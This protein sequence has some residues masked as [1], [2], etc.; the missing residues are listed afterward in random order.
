MG[1]AITR[2]TIRVALLCYFGAAAVRLR[3]RPGAASA[4]PAGQPLGRRASLGIRLARALWT[5]GC[6]AFLLHVASAFY[7]YH[8]GSHAAAFRHTAQRTQELFGWNFGGGL[9]V[10]YLFTV[11]WLADTL[12]WRLDEPSYL[13]RSRSWDAALH[14]FFLFMIV[15]GGLVFADGLVRWLTVAGLALL[16]LL[17]SAALLTR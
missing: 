3:S 14:V 1:E 12:W 8:H 16:A 6:A 5:L 9:F 7:F 10:N 13:G 17:A 4:D 2:W 11:V 15:N